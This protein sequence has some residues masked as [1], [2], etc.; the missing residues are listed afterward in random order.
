MLKIFDKDHNA[1]G[2]IVKYRDC[3]IESEVAT[4]DKTLSFVYLAKHHALENEMYVQT[5]D[6]EYV[7]KEVPA[8]TGSFPQIVAVLNL[9]DLQRD[10]WQTFS[11]TDTTIDAAVRTVLAGTG[12]TIGHCDVTKKRNAG[13][14]QV[15]TLDV[16]QNL[17]TAFMCEPV[18]DTINKTVSFYQ[19]RGEDKGV[20]FLSGLNL[21]KL[22]KKS[23]SY[24]FYTRIIP[25]G[26]NGLTIESVND[27]KNYLENYQYSSKVLTY[28]WKDESYTDAQALMEDAQ[29]KLE[30][31]SKPEKS[32]SADVRD[33]AKQKPEYSILAYGLGDTV[34]IIDPDTDI[35]EKQRIKKMVEYPQNPEKNTCEIANTVLTFE[36][37]Q[38][39]YQAAADIINYT[40]AGDGRYTGTINVSDI[41]NFESGLAD[42]STIGGIN[43][44]I[45][46][47]QGEVAGL[48]LTLGEL[49]TNYLRADEADLKYATIERLTVVDE[50]VHDLEGDYASFKSVTADEFAAH[51]ALIDTVVGDLADYK[52][53]V[54]EELVTAKGWMLEGAIGDAQISSVAANK[55]T[56]GTIDTAIVTIAGTDGKL[57]ISDNTIQISDGSTVRVQIGKDASGDYSMSVWDSSG[58]LI[59]DALGATEHTIQRQIIRDRMIADDAAIQALKIDFQSF[60]TALTEQGVVISGTVV[61]VGSKTLNVVLSEQEQINT[62]YGETLSTHSSKIAANEQ[63]ILLKVSTQVYE[64]DM[65]AMESSLQTVETSVRIMDGQI[66]ALVK[67]NTI[68]QDKYNDLESRTATLELSA[69][70]F[71]VELASTQKTVSDNYVT[72]QDYTDA[73]KASAISTA[74][75]DAT[76]KANKALS[77]AKADATAKADAAK[78]SAV[79]T[80]ATDAT[81]K[82]NNAK[83]AAITAAAADAT[84]KAN[85]A[86]SAA[87]S[88]AASD[89]TTKAN[90]ALSS[91]KSYADE[92]V[93]GIEIGG[94]NL[95]RNTKDFESW[96]VSNA[97]EWSKSTDIDGFSVYSFSASDRTANTWNRIIPPNKLLYKDLTKGITVSFMV[98]I[99]DI[100]VFKELSSSGNRNVLVGLQIYNEDGTRIGWIENTYT[101]YDYASEL[102]SGEWIKASRYY[103]YEDLAIVYTS[104]YTVDDIF[105]I[106]VSWVLTLNGSIHIKKCKVEL[107]TKATDWTPA[108]EDTQSQIDNTNATIA[109]HTETLSTHTS[110]IAANESAIA[111][112]VTTQDFNSYKTTVN[113]ELTSAKSR[114]TTAESSITA[115]KGE[116]ALKVEQ[117]DVDTAVTNLQIGGRNVIRNSAFIN[118]LKYWSWNG[119]TSSVDTDRTFNGHP[120]IKVCNTGLTGNRWYGLITR[121]L[122]Q[123]PTSILA[124]ETWTVS[125]YY[126][127][128]D[129]STIDGEFALEVKGIKEGATSDSSIGGATSLK[130][131]NTVEGAWTKIKKT[132]TATED[133]S[134]CFVYA[135]ISRNGTVWFADFKLEKGNK[136]TDWTPAPEDVD[137]SISAVDAKFASYSTTSE[138]E[139]AIT[140]AKS[141]ITSEVSETY[142]TKA[143]LETVDG[144]VTTLEDWQS[145]ASQKITKDGII[146]TV[147]NYYA[148]QSDLD[149]VENRV[150]EAETQILQQADE[151][152]LRVKKDGIINAIN[153]STEEV[154]ISAARITLAGAT[155]ADSFT[156]TNLHV[157]GNSV[158]DGTLRA[159]KG[160]IAGWDINSTSISTTNSSGNYI[161]LGNGSSANQDVLYVRTGAG[162]TASP[163]NWPVIIRATGEAMFSN[164][165]IAG[166]IIAA[167]ITAKNSYSIH[168]SS[169]NKARALYSADGSIGNT[170]LVGD[171]FSSLHL[172][173][174]LVN[175][176]AGQVLCGEDGSWNLQAGNIHCA[177]LY[178][179]TSSINVADSATSGNPGVR[180]GPNDDAKKVF[181]YNNGIT[182]NLWL[183]SVHNGTTKWWSI[184]DHLVQNASDIRLKSDIKPTKINGLEKI[185]QMTVKS[186]YRT[187]EDKYYQAGFVADDL[188]KIDC[189][190]VLGGGYTD[191][192]HPYY[193]S[194]N[195]LYLTTY[196]I[197]GIQEL[198]S[199]QV[200][201][202]D[203]IL[204]VE[205]RQD[206]QQLL[207]EQLMDENAKLKKRVAQLEEQQAA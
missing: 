166:T 65:A 24:D 133:Y 105:Y 183:Q 175:R 193:K 15:S 160:T 137:S 25:I 181:L 5:K 155:I 13:M 164:A 110:Q 176:N 104:G 90:S 134:N 96:Y 94:R 122:P 116:I 7:I 135:W 158:F 6:D 120:T 128:E 142:S 109:T 86:Q 83:N 36:E 54:S 200:E 47:M 97:D 192:G 206:N 63:E 59:W 107:G 21:K 100:S 207:I 136:A 143:E 70:N 72:L 23:T 102:V 203:R 73:A 179:Y 201:H 19:Q 198:Y 64:S 39:K 81:T 173:G 12:W 140:V 61:Q 77:D 95:I 88:T 124:G 45:T 55:L 177:A 60:D 129:A 71:A 87:I 16:I 170:L 171:G 62:E 141:E 156:A 112:R 180:I 153:L 99:D 115:M 34:T 101:A 191:D 30:D 150:T 20:Y 163:Y 8:Q 28:I 53:V 42:S 11:V 92:A 78:A 26:Q 75:S 68:I 159:T 151:I 149:T 185:N 76:S 49:E 1:I 154:K 139:S 197:K 74:A 202:T 14:I 27:G 103:S 119:N 4:G 186:F 125:C 91:A 123:K 35:R 43:N 165:T 33:L 3:K 148:Y 56:A 145:E 18:F 44:S 17:C 38:Q 52:T 195:P 199:V 51:T 2:H 66:T 10:M 167:S 172:G 29:L 69:D 114:L 162:T 178:T 117:K 82:A 106:G 131:S 144:K 146:A 58:N 161:Y 46:D 40:V 121:Y 113:E 168:D 126:Y 108:P 9:E 147:G 84:T 196:A 204:T 188:E 157:T 32:F 118:G 22:Q 89:A 189:N 111:L 48:K 190:L 31:L 93:D 80:A 127:V 98:K 182:G 132:F 67:D 194:I 130:S 187:D 57:Q 152:S 174:L 184:T 41:L 85:A 205:V 138:M 50:Y 37:L 169:G 79:S